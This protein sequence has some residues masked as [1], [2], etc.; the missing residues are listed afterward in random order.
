[1][2][3]ALVTG[4]R[5]FGAPS[6]PMPRAQPASLTFNRDIAHCTSGM[7]GCHRPGRPAP[8]SLLTFADA[9]G[10]KQIAEETAGRRMPPWLPD[11]GRDEFVG[12]RLLSADQIGVIQQWAAEG[13]IEGAAADLPPLP[14]WTDGWHLGTPD[15]IVTLTNIYT[16]GA[17]G[18]DVYRIFVLPIPHHGETCGVAIRQQDRPLPGIDRTRQSRRLD[19]EDPVSVR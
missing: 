18:R 9:S 1:M 8:F 11:Q 12:A 6:P 10:Q 13:A 7:R 4:L 2:L 16:L 14:K 3:A 17:E 19:E 5:T 15:V